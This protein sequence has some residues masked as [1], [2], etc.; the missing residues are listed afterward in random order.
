MDR[1]EVCLVTFYLRLFRPGHGHDSSPVE[2]GAEHNENVPDAVKEA[3]VIG[4]K[5]IGATGVADPFGQNEWESQCRATLIYI[6]CDEYDGPAHGNVEKEGETWKF[7]P[8]EDFIEYTKHC[9]QPND[10]K[11][12]PSCNWVVAID[13]VH[14][15]GGIAAGYEN[16]DADMV[17]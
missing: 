15:N 12:Y 17:K 5:E 14:G 9:N 8:K 1:R 6:G 11:K 4:S 10:S 16:I 3:F 2:Q 13:E 7:V